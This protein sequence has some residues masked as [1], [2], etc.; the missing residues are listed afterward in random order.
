[1]NRLEEL[2]NHL[3]SLE[4]DFKKFYEKENS[5]A[6]TRVR[7]GMQAL[8]KLANDIRTEVQAKKSTGEPK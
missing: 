5:S 2:R 8:K 1:M 7:K 3:T 6:G 4:E